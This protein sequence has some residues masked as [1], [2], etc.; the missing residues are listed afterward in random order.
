VIFNPSHLN[1]KC[2]LEK[3]KLCLAAHMILKTRNAPGTEINKF[4]VRLCE[5][6]YSTLFKKRFELYA[7]RRISLFSLSEKPR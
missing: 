2:G 5:L 4:S 3:V 7:A 6:S 1:R